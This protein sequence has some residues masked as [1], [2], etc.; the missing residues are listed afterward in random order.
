[1]NT[2]TLSIAVPDGV[3]KRA[4]RARGTGAG[5]SHRLPLGG[6]AVAHPD[7]E[8]LSAAAGYDWLGSAFD[9]P[10]GPSSGPRR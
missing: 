10:G 2:A 1:M 6:P 5:R 7:R 9:P 4:G 8:A 3:T